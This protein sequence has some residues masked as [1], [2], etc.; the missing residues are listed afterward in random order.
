MKGLMRRGGVIL[1]LC[2][3]GAAR[4]QTVP[5]PEPPVKAVPQTERKT[6][7]ERVREDTPESPAEGQS[8]RGNRPERSAR[9]AQ[10][11]P[12]REARGSRGAGRVK[13]EH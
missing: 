10:G 11:N 8:A 13:R 1:L 9:G 4:A 12:G 3:A 5:A 2:G 7:P 6:K